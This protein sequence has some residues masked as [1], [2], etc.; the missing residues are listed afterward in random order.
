VCTVPLERIERASSSF[1]SDDSSEIRGD[2]LSTFWVDVVWW[3]V[4]PDGGGGLV[5]TGWREL[6]ATVAA[7]LGSGAPCEGLRDV[8]VRLKIVS[9]GGALGV[10]ALVGFKV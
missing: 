8:E 2:T 1:S 6:G 4:S 9:A 10:G 5:L 3:L 7:G